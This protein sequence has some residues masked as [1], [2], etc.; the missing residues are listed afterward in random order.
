LSLLA[1][2]RNIGDAI[3]DIEMTTRAGAICATTDEAIDMT[4]TFERFLH[5]F[6]DEELIA[7]AR[8]RSRVQPP[9]WKTMQLA[10]RIE[11]DRRA[12]HLDG[13]LAEVTMIPASGRGAHAG[14][15]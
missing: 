14:T 8:E 15:A 9:Y 5:A 4:K 12:L 7:F 6:T 11:A 13:E 3:R 1:Q 2:G 10:L